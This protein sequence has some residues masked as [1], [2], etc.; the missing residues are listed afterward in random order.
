M[1]GLKSQNYKKLLKL[2]EK[3]GHYESILSLLYWDDRVCMNPKAAKYRGKQ[4]AIITEYIHKQKTSKNYRK[5]IESI[6]PEEYEKYSPE[7]VN[8]KW[9]KFEYERNIKIPPKLIAKLSQLIPSSLQA[10]E[11]DKKG[12]K[13]KHLLPFLKKIIEINRE[14]IEK[15]GYEEEPYEALVK[16]YEIDINPKQIEKIFTKLKEKLIPLIKKYKDKTDTKIDLKNIKFEKEKL[17]EFCKYLVKKISNLDIRLDPTS[18]PFATTISP[19]DVRITTRYTN[20]ESAIFGTLHELGHAIYD[21]YLPTDKYFGQPVSSSV[22]LSIHESQSR[23]FEN[24]I[25][26]SPNFWKHF[27]SELIKYIPEIKKIKPEEFV[28]SINRIELQPIRTEA[29]ETTYNLHIIMRFNIEREIFNKNIKTQEIPELWN[30]TF[31][32]YFGYYPKDD[33]EGILQDIHWAESL[34]GY[35]PTYTLGNLIAAQIYNTLQNKIKIEEIE[36]GKFENI[37][38]FLKENIYLKGKTYTTQELVEKITNEKI[39]P[40]YFIKYLEKKLQNI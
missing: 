16:G 40:D 5:L 18:H 33:S 31:K 12:K 4:I 21:Y 34:F 36:K 10:W 15:W 29:D 17:E 23:F 2:N 13:F 22:S 39:N 11:K 30:E 14:M 35:F 38:D 37:I 1:L 7:W 9:W 19:F 26:R 6:S 8:I 24:L 25:G 32:E 28:K 20:I 27:Y 3:L